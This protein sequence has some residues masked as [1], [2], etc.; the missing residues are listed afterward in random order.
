MATPAKAAVEPIARQL[1]PPPKMTISESADIY[2]L[3][4][5]PERPS[6]L[7]NEQPTQTLTALLT[8]R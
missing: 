6:R 3:Q 5:S 7:A 4:L 8:K 2:H 1:A